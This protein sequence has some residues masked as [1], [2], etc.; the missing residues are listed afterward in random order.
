MTQNGH[1][2]GQYLRNCWYVAAWASEVH[3]LHMMR[4]VMLGEPV[5]LYRKS[6][7]AAVALEDRC[8]H[9]HAPLSHGRMKGDNIE[10]AYHGL[11]FDP[12]GQ[13]VHIP[14]Q[15]SIPPTACVKSYPVAE[16]H[17]W[18][19]IWMGD[20]A[21][22]DEALIPDFHWMDDPDYGWRGETLHVKGNYLLVI[23][24]LM[25]LTHLPAL[26]VG[27]LG[28]T[29]IDGNEADAL[30]DEVRADD[31]HLTRSLSD[32]EPPPYFRMMTGVNKDER[33][34]RWMDTHFTPPSFVRLDIGIAP[35]GSGGL[36]GDRSGARAAFNMNAVTPETAASC[37]YFWS[38]A[39]NFAPDDPSITEVDFRMTQGAFQQDVAIIEGQQANIDLNPDAPRL[40][41]A[42]D[43][44]GLQ[45]TRIVEKLIRDEQAAG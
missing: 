42:A 23:E 20:P 17:Q 16:R 40:N 35:A 24:N 33:V 9:R 7:G 4:R 45:A 41:L 44:Y 12:D 30:T 28:T 18:I 10:C 5:V 29:H 19:W 43:K 2:N 31:L 32:V 3:R 1:G 34:D 25:D 15:D 11:V 8:I 27:T 39:Q 36:D 26:H 6:D 21:R 22:A 37:H 14:S 38:Q 13:C